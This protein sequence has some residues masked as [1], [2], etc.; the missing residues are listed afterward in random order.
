LLPNILV[1]TET[2][3]DPAVPFSLFTISNYSLFRSDRSSHGGG[4]G[5]WSLYQSVEIPITVPV[6]VKTN[7]LSLRIPKFNALLIAIYH[8]YWGANRAH[9]QVINILETFIECNL[10]KDER[11]LFLFNNLRL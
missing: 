8:P 2:W 6:D 3:L 7:I 9:K 4:I 5:I 11:I 1:V 10:T